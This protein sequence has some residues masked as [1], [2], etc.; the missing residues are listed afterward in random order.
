VKIDLHTH[1]IASPDGSLNETHYRRMLESGGLDIIAVTDHNTISF[2][3]ELNKKLG[4][5]IIVGEEIMTPQGE[6]IGLYL[7]EAV[8]PGLSP[9]ETVAAIKTQGGLVYIP[10]PFETRRKGLQLGTLNTIAKDIDIVETHNGRAVFQNKSRTAGDWAAKN[11]LPGAAGSDSHGWYGWGRTYSIIDSAPAK[12]TLAKLLA[13]A[14]HQA[15]SPGIRGVLYP[16][17]NKIFRKHRA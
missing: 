15:G 7:K 14:E 17:F 3:L 13:K 10:H 5:R 6:I 2:A 4:D 1:S 9:A 16:K 11:K 8:K 12:A